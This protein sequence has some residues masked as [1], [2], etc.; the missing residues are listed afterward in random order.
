MLLPVASDSLDEE[1]N[2]EN[3]HIVDDGKWLH[4]NNPK[5]SPKGAQDDTVG[6]VDKPDTSCR[7]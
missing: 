4:G 6:G 7:N 5:G 1:D 2:N 3:N